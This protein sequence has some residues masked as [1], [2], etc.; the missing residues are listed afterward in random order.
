MFSTSTCNCTEIMRGY[1]TVKLHVYNNR[2]D[3]FSVAALLRARIYSDVAAAI[4]FARI[5]D[6]HLHCSTKNLTRRP[7]VKKK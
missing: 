5:R 3:G 4:N 6:I 1:K 7:R 2:E